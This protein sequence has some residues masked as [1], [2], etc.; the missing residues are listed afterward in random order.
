MPRTVEIRDL[1]DEVYDALRR[2]SAEFGLSVPEYLRREAE[3]L[4]TG[5]SVMEWI[6]RTRRGAGPGGPLDVI[7][8]LD[9]LRGPWPG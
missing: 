1:D 8:A 2:R 5:L 4:A 9:D 3:R 7:G 6:A